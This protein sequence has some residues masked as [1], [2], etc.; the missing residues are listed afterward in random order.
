MEDMFSLSTAYIQQFK[1]EINLGLNGLM[2]NRTLC[3]IDIYLHILKHTLN[4]YNSA[5][6]KSNIE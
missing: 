5:M 1:S 3:N 2:H 6:R 4:A